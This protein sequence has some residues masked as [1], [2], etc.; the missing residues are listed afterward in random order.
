MTPCFK[1]RNPSWCFL[2]SLSFSSRC[3]CDVFFRCF[4]GLS[5]TDGM[6]DWIEAE[7]LTHHASDRSRLIIRP[8][9]LC[10]HCGRLVAGSWRALKL[11]RVSWRKSQYVGGWQL[12]AGGE[13]GGFEERAK[14]LQC[15]ESY[16]ILRRQR[17]FVKKCLWCLMF[18]SNET[19][20]VEFIVVTTAPLIE[21]EITAQSDKITASGIQT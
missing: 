12:P 9:R 19:G 21:T 5:N 10:F 4:E 20:H 17:H 14:V 18:T 15:V 13:P 8:L 11:E 1:E 6:T 16:W 3:I 2:M 7:S